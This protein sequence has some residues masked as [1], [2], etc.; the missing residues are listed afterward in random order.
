MGLP[1]VRAHVSVEE[2]ERG[3]V[4]K[5]DWGYTEWLSVITLTLA[6]ILVALGKLPV[7]LWLVVAGGAGA[8]VAAAQRANRA[9]GGDRPSRD[10]AGEGKS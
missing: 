7:E 5:L 1:E 4:M 3:G 8:S 9:N 10:T 2:V 6:T